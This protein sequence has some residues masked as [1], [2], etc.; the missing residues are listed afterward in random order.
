MNEQIH[1]SSQHSRIICFSFGNQLQMFHTQWF[2]FLK[3]WVQWLKEYPVIFLES[4]G[5]FMPI[6]T[7]SGP[8]KES[9]KILIWKKIRRQWNFSLKTHW[10]LRKSQPRS[11]HCCNEITD[12][13]SLAK[14]LPLIKKCTFLLPKGVAFDCPSVMHSGT[15]IHHCKCLQAMNVMGLHNRKTSQIFVKMSHF[16]FL[17]KFSFLWNYITSAHRSRKE[18]KPD[19]MHANTI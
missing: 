6:C 19:L 4:I 15:G 1:I 8:I 16:C 10:T 5:Q 7:Q 12:G 17:N 9:K 3:I 18:R 14:L 11:S 13:F 2:K